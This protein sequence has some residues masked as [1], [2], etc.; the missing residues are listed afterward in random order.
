MLSACSF[1]Q[2]AILICISWCLNIIVVALF[3]SSILLLMNVHHDFHEV[4]DE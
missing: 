3:Y 2:H 4:S 1:A